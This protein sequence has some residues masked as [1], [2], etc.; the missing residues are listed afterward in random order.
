MSFTCN[1]YNYQGQPNKIKKNIG[2]V[3]VGSVTCTPYEPVSDL[4]GY[5]IIGYNAAVEACNYCEIAGRY[6][7][8]TDFVKRTAQQLEV[9][10]ELDPLMTFQ[11]KILSQDAYVFRTSQ[12]PADED[13]P[14]YNMDINDSKIPRVIYDRVTVLK[15]EE[16]GTIPEF[17]ASNVSTY[18]QVIGGHE[19]EEVNNNA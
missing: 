5:V 10:L 9:R 2:E 13:S 12:Q 6:Y 19:E 3:I 14:G 17:N 18:V 7:Y 8:V 4:H 1:F 16:T 15:P 11:T